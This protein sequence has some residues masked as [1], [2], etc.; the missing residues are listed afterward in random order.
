MTRNHSN[1]HLRMLPRWAPNLGLLLATL[2]A[3]QGEP[4]DDVEM[5]AAK[6]QVETLYEAEA[7]TLLAGARIQPASGASKGAVIGALNAMGAS[8]T[9]RNVDGG[10]GGTGKLRLRYANGYGAPRSLAVYV[11]G[12]RLV[13]QSFEA[14]TSWN[15]FAFTPPADV[16]LRAGANNEIRI[17][18]DADSVAAADID[19]IAITPPEVATTT[20]TYEAE[21]G[22]LKNGAR[23][24][25][26]A[27]A[28]GDV[29]GAINPVFASVAISGVDGGAGGPGSVKLRYAN[30]YSTV[31]SLSLYVNG[32]KAQPVIFPPTGSWSTF[33]DSFE[34]PVTLAAGTANEVRIQ[35]DATDN[36]AGDIDYI[37]VK[38]RASATPAPTTPPPTPTTPPPTTPPPTGGTIKPTIAPLARTLNVA[39]GQSIAAAAAQARSGDRIVV[40]AGTF[41]EPQFALPPGVSLVGSGAGSTVIRFSDFVW[42]QGSIRLAS[43][44][45]TAG[46][47]M[48]TDLTLDGRG[49]RA[50]IGLEIHDRT[51]I[52]VQRV[53][54]TGFYEAGIE[55]KGS[56][57]EKSAVIEI[58]DFWIGETSR[59][60]NDGSRG[61]LMT[62]GN[63]DRLL[64]RDGKFETMT[65]NPIG[66]IA[67]FNGSGYAF[68]ARPYYE[69]STMVPDPR[70]SNSRFTNN[71]WKCKSNAS[72]NGGLS[73]NFSFEVWAVSADN[74]EIDKNTFGCFVSLE[75]NKN[76]PV[77]RT[78]WLHDN[79]FQIATGPA[80][81][82]AIPNVLVERN[83]FDFTANTN[84]WSVFG[85]FNNG[86]RIRGQRVVD[87]VF[88]LGTRAPSLFVYT[89]PIEDWRF[90]RNTIRGSSA[91]T[92]VELRRANSNGS[93]GLTIAGNTFE[94]ADWR[95]F[96]YAE[97]S[98]GQRPTN[99]TITP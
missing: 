45:T 64:V 99:V 53:K 37:V 97:G 44:R 70:L 67:G 8:V 16:P 3:C 56:R 11:N 38:A 24:Q 1:D 28:S 91:P 61:N 6:L 40:A 33:A 27:N 19:A 93:N 66:P 13:Q 54:I 89:A 2:C 39:A 43:E 36:P 4:S 76:A 32:T 10:V 9:V 42:W 72:W 79:R 14:T 20:K 18:R 96:S 62:S 31:R 35:R 78:F 47:Q 49:A 85:E 41:D 22:T 17:Q 15:S 59:E 30:G 23:I 55:I 69:G 12:T 77:A 82:F 68:K 75:Y 25:S 46:Q 90:E 51:D 48:I 34:V 87:N 81:E 84:A 7:G 73:P 92:L 65:A 57:N 50:F 58:A 98:N 29:V 5:A 26:A 21:R 94:R 86:T 63:V 88:E 80:I 83:V 71:T 60:G 52:L 95:P 74:V